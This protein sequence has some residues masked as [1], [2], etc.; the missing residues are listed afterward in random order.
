MLTSAPKEPPAALTRAPPFG[1]LPYAQRLPMRVRSF[2]ALATGKVMTT[3]DECFECLPRSLARTSEWRRA[4]AARFPTDLRNDKAASA[5][6]QLSTGVGDLSDEQWQR[7]CPMF[8]P[9]DDRWREVVARC[10]RDVCFRSNPQSFAD[11]VET[12]IDAVL[13]SA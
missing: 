8:N 6:W 9:K 7:L 5:L 3:K 1:P 10:S 11:Y 4:Q 2:G 12:I 13:V